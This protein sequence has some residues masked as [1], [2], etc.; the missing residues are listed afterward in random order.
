M[1][2]E[3]KGGAASPGASEVA[4]DAAEHATTEES[5]ARELAAEDTEG[6]GESGT[7]TDTETPNAGDE[8]PSGDETETATDE[9]T[10]SEE[11]QAGS[12]DHSQAEGVEE[13]EVLADGQGAEG[14]EGAADIAEHVARIPKLSDEQKAHVSKLIQE[15]VGKATAKIRTA[16]ERAEAAEARVSELESSGP[17]DQQVR[18]TG[19][20]PLAEITTLQ[21]LQEKANSAQD[22][23]DFCEEAMPLL[24]RKPEMV[25]A[26]LKRLGIK[27]TNEETGEED[28]SR[29]SIEGFLDERQAKARRTLQR[30]IPARANYLKAEAQHSRKAEELY[31]WLKK[32]ADEKAKK[33]NEMLK[34]APV[35]KSFPSWKLIVAA[36]VNDI[37]LKE[38]AAKKPDAKKTPPLAKK[39]VVKVKPAA[40]VVSKTPNKPSA[41]ASRNTEAEKRFEETGSEKDLAASLAADM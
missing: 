33:F 18:P 23:L 2:K 38:A 41:K 24:K 10:G 28:F 26:Q 29:E 21:G 6:T 37:M 15:R 9:G 16:E 30:E 14:E 39:P 7:E 34:Q 27:L 17:A 36:A 3:L 32:P 31:P 1:A 40:I 12:E 4:E 25:A 8:S 22:V 35:L 11:E 20:G 13:G 5:L 19:G